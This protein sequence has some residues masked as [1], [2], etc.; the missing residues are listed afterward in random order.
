M[1][2]MNDKVRGYILNNSDYRETDAMIKVLTEDHGLLTFVAKG[3]KKTTSKNAMSLLP[4]C[5]SDLFFDYREGKDMF[6]LKRA[7][8]VKSYYSEDLSRLAALALISSIAISGYDSHYR[9]DL[10][11]DVAQAFTLCESEDVIGVIALF[12]AKMARY[13]GVGANVGGCV[14]CGKKKVVSFSSHDGGFLCLEHLGKNNT[15]EPSTLYK[16][17]LLNKIDWPHFR[18]LGKLE[19]GLEDLMIMAD[20]FYDHSDFDRRPYTFFLKMNRL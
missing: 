4:Y 11:G 20:L 17:R 12:M 3:A 13:L 2:A 15:L 8:L 7:E 5:V 18:E 6:T 1:A 16:I 19:F 14:I 9:T 10:Y